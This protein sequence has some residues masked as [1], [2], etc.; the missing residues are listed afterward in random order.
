VDSVISGVFRDTSRIIAISSDAI[1]SSSVGIIN[2]FLLVSVLDR[3]VI[4]ENFTFTLESM[5]TLMTG[6]EIVVDWLDF[7]IIIKNSG[8]SVGVTVKSLLCIGKKFFG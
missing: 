5:C 7:I 2:V 8:V 1:L 6:V 3:V 4:V